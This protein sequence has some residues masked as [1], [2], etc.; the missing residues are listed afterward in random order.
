MDYYFPVSFEQLQ[1]SPVINGK[2]DDIS[3]MSP[4]AYLAMRTQKPAFGLPGR[5]KYYRA[6]SSE[7]FFFANFD[8]YKQIEIPQRLITN[9]HTAVR[10]QLALLPRLIS[11]S[12]L[13]IKLSRKTVEPMFLSHYQDYFQFDFKKEFQVDPTNLKPKKI[14]RKL[15]NYWKDESKLRAQAYQRLKNDLFQKDSVVKLTGCRYLFQPGLVTIYYDLNTDLF[16]IVNE[17]SNE[18]VSG[19]I[20]SLCDYL[21]IYYFKW[22]GGNQTFNQSI[23]LGISSDIIRPPIPLISQDQEYLAFDESRNVGLPINYDPKEWWANTQQELVQLFLK[24]TNKTLEWYDKLKIG[25]SGSIN[26]TSEFEAFTLLQLE[27]E[28]YLTGLY[29]PDKI[30]N[31]REKTLNTDARFQTFD[32][33][34]ISLCQPTIVDV[35]ALIDPASIVAA[36]NKVRTLEEQVNDLRQSVSFQQIRAKEFNETVLHVINLFRIRPIDRPFVISMF[37]SKAVNKEIDSDC[38]L[39][40]NTSENS[41]Y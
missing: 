3:N 8:K 22:L 36:G 4:Q 30:N 14:R 35:K 16:A 27:A 25:D 9:G 20:A 21:D 28:N 37:E 33:K 40:L 39:F 19:G 23:K 2:I 34:R 32:R 26:K 11:K 41:I 1:I 31:I 17:N 38:V 15:G 29:R 5:E 13:N 18:F 12:D 10:Q 7:K 24:S 6:D